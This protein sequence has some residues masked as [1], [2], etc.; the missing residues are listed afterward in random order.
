M[1]FTSESGSQNTS[2]NSM[3]SQATS[4]NESR[5][6]GEDQVIGKYC[7]FE[8]LKKKWKCQDIEEVKEIIRRVLTNDIVKE[9]EVH[10]AR[11]RQEAL[12]NN[13]NILK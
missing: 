12:K 3:L 13:A 7:D 10:A 1:S 6:L 5:G 9:A 11:K 8:A 4:I 2:Q